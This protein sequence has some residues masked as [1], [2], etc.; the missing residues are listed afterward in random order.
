[1]RTGV[2]TPGLGGDPNAEALSDLETACL[3]VPQNTTVGYSDGNYT[4]RLASHEFEKILSHGRKGN[5]YYYVVEWT[6]KS[7]PPSN[8]WCSNVETN[9]AVEDYWRSIPKGDRPRKFK[10]YTFVAQTLTDAGTNGKIRSDDFVDAMVIDPQFR[11]LASTQLKPGII[12][13]LRPRK[14]SFAKMGILAIPMNYTASN[15]K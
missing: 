1:M 6:H 11:K 12:N 9:D 13:G 15:R 14:V 5:R 7:F 3:T 8:V 2:V 4:A 10:G